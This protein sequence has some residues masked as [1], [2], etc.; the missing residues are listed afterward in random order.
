MIVLTRVTK[1]RRPIM[2][3][4]SIIRAKFTR[5]SKNTYFAAYDSEDVCGTVHTLYTGGWY[6]AEVCKVTK[7]DRKLE[8]RII[9]SESGSDENQKLLR[10]YY[11]RQER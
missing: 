11:K 1:N 6:E 9:D 10:K 7:R 5:D 4:I 2:K 3:I 8:E